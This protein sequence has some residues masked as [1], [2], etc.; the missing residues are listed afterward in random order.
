MATRTPPGTASAPAERSRLSGPEAAHRR[1]ALLRRALGTSDLLAVT[2]ALA[3]ATQTS[4]STDTGNFFWAAIVTPLWLVVFGVFGLYDRDHRSIQHST[5]DELPALLLACV[6]NTLGLAWGLQFTPAGEF[7]TASIATLAIAAFIA[8]AIGRILVRTLNR[9]LAGGARGA[10]V[11]GGHA[12]GVVARR[13]SF[14]PEARLRAVGFIGPDASD[15]GAE[16]LPHLGSLEDV[17]RIA[18]EQ[19]IERIVATDVHLFSGAEIE[20]LIEDCKLSGLGLTFLTSHYAHLGPGIELSRLADLPVIDFRFSEPS[21]F[22]LQLKRGLDLVV[23]IPF[24]IALSPLL[25]A[26]ALSIK[27]GSKGPVFFR[28]VRIGKGGKPFRM[29]KF[30]TMVPD[31]EARLSDLVDID[32]LEEPTFKLQD[33]PRVT[34]VGRFLRRYSLDELPQFFNVVAGSMSLVGPRPEEEAIVA[35]YDE[36]QRM[37]LAVKPGVTGPMQ[38]YG[39]ADL[40][41]DERLALE[42]DYLDKLSLM[43]DIAILLRTPR[44]VIRGDGAY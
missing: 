22:T 28:Q 11:G 36:R 34:T 17:R 3:I 15:P 8:T 35:L 13:L 20:G 39:R 10:I 33:D 32:A 31:A 27:L 21:R 43:S 40:T 5:I 30:R 23:S 25:L 14:H 37:R 19:G 18:D 44:A 7:D 6:V 29:V 26:V 9:E 24:L 4:S 12:A 42:R 2:L 41:F 16:D 1:A 38:V